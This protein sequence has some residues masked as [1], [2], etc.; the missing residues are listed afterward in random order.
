[1]KRVYV[2]EEICM[3]CRLC[4]V[5]CRVEHSPSRDLVKAFKQDTPAPVARVRVETRSP[6]SFSVR[7]QHCREPYCVYACLTGA[8]SRDPDS[9]AVVV[10]DERCVGCW[11]CLLTCPYGSIARDTVRGKSAKCDLCPN[12][13]APVC[14]ANCPNEAL[15]FEEDEPVEEETAV[16]VG[17]TAPEVAP[18]SGDKQR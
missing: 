15:V 9:G 2:K 10:D 6:V 12:A 14:V 16:L 5:Y 17:A 11:T 8:L 18:A 4:E 7:C 1:M 13:E 3:G